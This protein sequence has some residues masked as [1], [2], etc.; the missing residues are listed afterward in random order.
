MPFGTLC[1]PKAIA[2]LP[3]KDASTAASYTRSYLFKVDPQCNAGKIEKLQAMQTEWQRLLPMVGDFVWSQFLHGRYSNKSLSSA[4]GK[5]SVF[6]KTPLVTSMK[7][8]MAVAVEGQFKTWKSN[9]QARITRLIMRS[10]KYAKAVELRHQ[11]LWLNSMQLWQV[12]F[13]T[14]QSI[15]ADSKTKTNVVHVD[16]RCSLLLRRYIRMYL[17]RFKGPRFDNLP[18]QVN[19]M[20]SVWATAQKT[21]KN[22]VRHWLRV[23]T[24][25]RGQ[26]IELPIRTNTYAERFSGVQALT[27]SLVTRAGH[28]YVKVCK[29]LPKAPAR[30]PKGPVLGL[31]TGM[32]NLVATSEGAIFGQG[33]NVK[34][35]RWD[36]RLQHLTKGLQGA[37]VYRLSQAKRYRDFVHRMRAWVTSEVKG[38]VNRAL[39]L[40]QPSTVVIEALNFSAQEGTLSKKMNRLVRHMGTGVF[41]Q[42]L[43]MKAEEQGFRLVE[44]NPA[45]TSQE[46][47]SCGFISRSNRKGNRFLC[48]CCGKQAH[49]DAQAARNLVERFHTGRVCEYVKHTTLGMQGLEIWGSK[50][51]AQVEKATP[52]TLRFQG[53]IG[54]VQAGLR[55]LD[56]Q[57]ASLP[58]I[59]SLQRLLSGLSSGTVSTR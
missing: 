58:S 35:R 38:A 19:Q 21:K 11:L 50:L 57:G 26:R 40:G 2:T 7:Q 5:D 23:S 14:Q 52:G 36:E 49:A 22:G 59:Q 44:V 51:L 3:K 27:F 42:A 9:L 10:G 15:L 33:F 47:S 34:L 13:S 48:V 30:P 4:V 8:C 56:G 17:H 45:Y 12:P 55:K 18:M 20:S 28:W 37:G 53:V 25:E 54:H 24:L 29:K 31:D 43:A 6:G 32:L 39:K 46:C 41:Q 1:K 16:E